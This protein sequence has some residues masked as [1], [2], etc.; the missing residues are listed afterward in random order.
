[1]KIDARREQL[2][3]RTFLDYQQTSEFLKQPL[4]IDRA[5]RASEGEAR[6]A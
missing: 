6:S 3:K 1:M 2:L 5:A 4:I